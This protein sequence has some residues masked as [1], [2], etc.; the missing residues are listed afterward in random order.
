VIESSSDSN[1]KIS[2]AK[3]SSHTSCTHSD[4]KKI[5]QDI[6]EEIKRFKR[7]TIRK[8]KGALV[9]KNAI[10]ENHLFVQDLID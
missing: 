8:K 9:M 2:S 4:A 6:K 10:R 5:K 3:F 7:E 1:S